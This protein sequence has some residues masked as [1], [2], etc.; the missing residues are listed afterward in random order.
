MPF[1]PLF[2]CGGVFEYEHSLRRCRIQHPHT[3][4]RSLSLSDPL[5][6]SRSF[7]RTLPSPPLQI[8]LTTVLNI[9]RALAGLALI[10]L[11]L[12]GLG[13]ASGP[14]KKWCGKCYEKENINNPQC[15]L[16]HDTFF[17]SAYPDDYT[18]TLLSCNG[19]FNTYEY[20]DLAP[21]VEIIVDAGQIFGTFNEAPAKKSRR[22]V[23]I[24]D[25]EDQ[26]LVTQEIDYPSRGNLLFVTNGTKLVSGPGERSRTV[27]YNCTLDK[28]ADENDVTLKAQGNFD[29]WPLRTN[30]TLVNIDMLMSAVKTRHIPFQDGYNA[31]KFFPFGFYTSWD[32]L[33]SQDLDTALTQ[34][35]KDGLTM[36]HPVP[37]YGKVA[38]GDPASV[39]NVTRFLD[40]A[41]KAGLHVAYDLRRR[42]EA[43]AIGI[44]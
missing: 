2:A 5:F 21:G 36:I 15:K 14:P 18:P 39:A 31:T 7:K 23:T 27:T 24:Y 12:P 44:T 4:T 8:L 40:A 29:L 38:D 43:Q 6:H 17:K 19:R 28:G 37:D 1:R 42:V 30:G 35:A 10:A 20:E 33:M 41:F 11:M 32:W 3:Q 9:M 16:S 13:A 26:P 34:M 25:A 22:N